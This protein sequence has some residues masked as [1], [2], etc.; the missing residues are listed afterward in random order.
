[1]TA[2]HHKIWYFFG[3]FGNFHKK[4]KK[5]TCYFF[6][7]MLILPKLG[8]NAKIM[9]AV[10][11]RKKLTAMIDTYGSIKV[12]EVSKLFGVSSETV[13]NDLRYLDTQGKIQREFGG[14][15]S[16]NEISEIPLQTRTHENI[17]VKNRIARKALE[18]I[19]GKNVVY[20][21]SGSTLIEFSKLLLLAGEVGTKDNLAI[22]TNSF[23]VVDVLSKSFRN[24]YFLGGMVNTNSYST[25]GMWATY[26]LS[27]LKMDVA[28]LGTSGFQSHSGPCVK[29]FDD[30]EYKKSVMKASNMTVVLADNSK[31]RSNAII[32][33]ADWNEINVLITDTDSPAEKV[34]GIKEFTQVIQV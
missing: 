13:R 17:E 15:V 16:V 24:L 1:M 10:E 34:E 30:A 23:Y 22:V 14:A 8:G 4:S 9:M 29:S 20:I 21:D 18:L 6:E 7:L 31:F 32:Q 5:I 3:I 28:F 19:K 27:T 12:S 25:S 33:Y 26:A 11:R 2:V